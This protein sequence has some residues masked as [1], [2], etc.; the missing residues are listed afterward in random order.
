MLDL[1][2]RYRY[3]CGEYTNFLAACLSAAM[4]AVCGKSVFES[5]RQIYAVIASQRARWRGNPPVERN[6]V[7]IPTK[8][9]GESH[10]YGYFSAHFP[11]IRGIAT[12]VLR[13]GSQ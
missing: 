11:S 5:A 6:Q 7:T 1:S 10:S 12:E 9:C 2:N 13:T 4:I 8:N 3:I